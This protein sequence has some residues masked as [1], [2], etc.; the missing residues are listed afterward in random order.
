MSKFV[1]FKS[2]VGRVT[3]AFA[4][5]LPIFIYAL[6]TSTYDAVTSYRDAQTIHSQNAAANNLI[7]GVYE[8]LM[9]RLATNNALLAEQPAGGDV[10]KEI[11]VRRSVAVKKI[12]AAFE[13][14]SAQD[15]PAKAM[16]L[17]ELKGAIDKANGYR[18]KA[19]AAV[20]QAKGARDAD[21]VKNLFVSLSELS[22]TSQKVW[23]AVLSNTSRLDPEL[24]RLSNIR[25]LAWNLRDTAGFERSHIAQSI[26]A[27][28]PIP[29]DKLV[30][31]NEI[32]AQLATMWK[33][34]GI[35][36][37][38]KDHAGVMA[39]V[40]SAKDG[41]YAKFQS[42]ADEMRKVSAAGGAYP[43][44][45]Q[46]WVDTTTPLLFTLLDI[47]YGAGQASETYTAS[48][49]D[50][51]V[52]KLGLSLGLLLLGIVIAAG[53]IVFAY[54]TVARPIGDLAGVVGDLTANGKDVSVPHQARVDEIGQMARSLQS[55][56]Q[57]HLD[58][59]TF[60]IEQ[61]RESGERAQRG[62]Q[63]GKLTADFEQRIG[64][65]VGT[66]TSAATELV[67]AAG[68]LSRTAESAQQMSGMVA[69]ASEEAS[70]NVQ[71]VAS[72]TEEMTS[73][74]NEIARQV[75]ESSRIASE[76]VSQAEKTDARINALSQAASRIGDVVKLITAIAEQTNLLA[77]NATIEAARA[78]EAGRGFA[79][80]AQEVK[81]LAAQTAK[82]TDEIGTQ[83]AGM[84]TATAESVNAIK[85][86][87]G[88]IGRISEIASA[89][90][91]AVEEQSA[92]TREI[93]RN[94][95]GASKG[96][97]QVAS[98]IG[99]VSKAAGETGSASSQ[100]LASAQSLSREGNVL[101]GEVEAFL[102][103]VRTA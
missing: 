40:Q 67:S 99:D 46:Q 44:S 84:Q 18:A 70:S 88:T 90:A 72:A 25:I 64:G 77:L 35:S 7:A 81:A 74:V 11:D 63:L 27:K 31:I 49:H 69:S 50:G 21:T 65:I 56:R 5:I 61:Q 16:L 85:E 2:V 20:K 102:R 52:V 42:L 15:F 12:G 80:V 22:A 51:A 103:S 58:M 4:I 1:G 6:G 23:A 17:G 57:G 24:G 32:R 47:M 29:A 60:R 3:M 91:A 95:Q 59:E 101:K 93:A 34:L 68:T 26:S 53:A 100:V 66:V 98:N 13:D 38:E 8:I 55:F 94:V 97:A 82:A 62:E 96:T 43:M 30:A 89:I 86:I 92:T 87:G 76:A 39:G 10:L 41:Y 71:S 83:I 79:V 73:S 75:Q 9:E 37:R 19:D 45:T 33:L 36:L 78:G 14:L 54:R 48:L 28:T